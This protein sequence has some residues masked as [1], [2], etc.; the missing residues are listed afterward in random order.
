MLLKDSV[1]IVTGSGR[2][3]GRAITLRFAK[4][5]AKLAIVD[6]DKERGSTVLEEVKGLGGTG[7]LIAADVSSSRQVSEM[8]EK[9]IGELGR[10]DILVNNAG[11]HDGKPFWKEPEELWQR[12]YKVNVIGTVLPSQAVVPH[13][14]K[15]RKGKIVNVSSKAA[16]VGEPGHAAYSAS[17]GAVLALTRAMAIELASYHITVNAVCPGPMYTDML[18]AA[19]PK[20]SDRE[21]LAAVTPLGRLGQPEDLVGIILYL[22]S[23][24]S[25]WCTGQAISVDG[26]LSI[27]K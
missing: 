17:K 13:M 24:E 27:L 14:I 22:S 3:L 6:L 12:M 20:E 21:A 5:G 2:G 10:I 7:T 15:R 19:M 4:E 26:G 18:L 25:N 9:V 16:V 23:E 1:A 8:V 11:I